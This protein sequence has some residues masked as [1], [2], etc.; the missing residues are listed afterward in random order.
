MSKSWSIAET[1]RHVLRLYGKAQV[2]LARSSLQSTVERQEFARIHYHDTLAVLNAFVQL[3]L[4]DKT[5][6]EV[7]FTR[8]DE[9]VEEFQLF[10]L[11]IGAYVTAFVQ[12]L[13]S[14]P[15]ILGHA[16]YY[17]LA[18]NNSGKPLSPR[19]I[20]AHAVLSL[21][22]AESDLKQLRDIY[23][24][25]NKGGAFLYIAAAANHSKHRSV[26]LPSI[27]EDQTGNSAERHKLSFAAFEYEG[28]TYPQVAIRDLLESEFDRC[29]SLIIDIGIELNAVLRHRKTHSQI[30]N[31]GG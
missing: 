14:I 1:K 6:F 16:I 29:S 11:K 4:R 12:S 13:H 9:T 10:N 7:A 21:L 2:N 27:S 18:L 15:D 24:E 25:L 17:S 31:S 19:G 23:S 3:R 22:N 5:L 26:V 20:N 28:K 30:A 8:D